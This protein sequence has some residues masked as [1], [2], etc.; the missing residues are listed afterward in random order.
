MNS[1]LK[2]K[3]IILGICGS[4]AA[5]KACELTS[6]LSKAGAN[7]FVLM[8]QSALKFVGKES[9]RALSANIVCVDT[10]DYLDPHKVNHIEIVKDADL[11]LIAPAS[12]NTIAKMANGFADNMLTDVFLAATCPVAIAPAMN[13]NM[14]YNAATQT[15]VE[16]LSKRG[17]KFIGQ[18]S[19]NLA[20]KT[21]GIGKFEEPNNIITSIIELFTEKDFT[22][23]VLITAG[24][25]CED[26]DP[27]R[28]ISNRSTGKMG[29]ALASAAKMRGAD[30]CLLC[31]SNVQNIPNAIYTERFRSTQDLYNLV[32]EKY[33]DFDVVIQCAAPADYTVLNY[34]AEK[35]K[36]GD[37]ELNLLLKRTP[38]I[39][40]TIGVTKHRNQIFIGFAAESSLDTTLA[41]KKLLDKNLDL[42]VYNN[43]LKEGAGFATDTNIATI[44]TKDYELELEKM[45]KFDLANTIIDHILRLEEK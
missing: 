44:I 33:K 19:G 1:I 15:N 39:A 10:F 28:F 23:K 4:I 40:K 37:S 11:L 35:I 20:C 2:N 8:T 43:I 22:K 9:L 34:S 29:L 21:E 45:S 25:T 38:D 18:V 26:I 14:W 36:K 5:Y 16:T 42:I 3:K 30:V 31:G 32:T 41:H 12:A 17:C 27:V 13:T 24:A 6:L 7:V